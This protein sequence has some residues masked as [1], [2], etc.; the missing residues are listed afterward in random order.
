ML[1]IIRVCLRHGCA[2]FSVALSRQCPVAAK[3][4]ARKAQ[5]LTAQVRTEQSSGVPRC[6]PAHDSV[7]S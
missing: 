3:R 7:P 1:R 5:G 6:V 4:C 2:F